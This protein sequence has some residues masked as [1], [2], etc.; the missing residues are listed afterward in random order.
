MN[1]NLLAEISF[2]VSDLLD[3]DKYVR[4][5]E[6]TILISKMFQSRKKFIEAR[7]VLN[8]FYKSPKS[9]VRNLAKDI[10]EFL[11]TDKIDN[12]SFEKKLEKITDSKAVESTFT[13]KF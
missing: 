5:H 11:L 3:F 7:S 9:D 10:S 12:Y 1:D 6:D 13:K 8:K 4:N 2:L